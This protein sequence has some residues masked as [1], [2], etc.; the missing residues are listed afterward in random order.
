M[1]TF[2]LYFIIALFVIGSAL[3]IWFMNRQWHNKSDQ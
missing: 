1:G 2:I 3:Y